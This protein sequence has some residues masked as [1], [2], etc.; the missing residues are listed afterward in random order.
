M[1]GE[2]TVLR[3]T[4]RR[5]TIAVLTI[6]GL[7][8]FV[9]LLVLGAAIEWPASLDRPAAEMLPAIDANVGAVRVGYVAYLAYSVA[10]WPLAALVNAWIT[11]PGTTPVMRI[12]LRIGLGFAL[13]SAACRSLGILRWLFPMPVLADQRAEATAAGT[14]TG[15][16][17]VTYDTV[18]SYAGAVGEVLG[19]GLFSGIW[20]LIVAAVIVRSQV[21]PPWIGWFGV[22]A[23]VGLLT[24][25]AEAFGVELGALIAVQVTLVQLWFLAL[26]V[27][28]ARSPD[29]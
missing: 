21:L 12:S 10:F 15:A 20:V 5:A 1:S 13:A 4:V 17:D 7:A 23:A 18:N 3:G 9:P 28:I 2:S 8:M 24:S 11:R 14:A 25:L 16:I 27:A 6:E 22:V 19:V 29:Q 26:A